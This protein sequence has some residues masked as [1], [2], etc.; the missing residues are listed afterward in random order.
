MTGI[1]RPA[2]PTKERFGPQ[3]KYEAFIS[4]KHAVSGSF[5]R[6]LELALKKY[7]RPLLKPPRQIFRDEQFLAPGI[8]LP[9]LIKNAL[10]QSRFLI[11]LV[12]KEAADSPW[13]QDELSRW[14]MQLGRTEQLIVVLTKDEIVTRKSSKKK[15]IEWSKTTALPRLLKSQLRTIPLY[16]DARTFSKEEHLDLEHP[17]FKALVNGIVARLRGIT[18]GEMSDEAVLQHRR[19]VR[20]RNITLSSLMLLILCTILALAFAVNRQ[21]LANQQREFRA[22]LQYAADI[23]NVAQIYTGD[24]QKS[25]AKEL[26][27][28]INH[29]SEESR[30]KDLRG[31]EWFLLWRLIQ[32]ELPHIGSKGNDDTRSVAFSPVS[33]NILA[34]GSFDGL[35]IYNI[36]SISQSESSLDATAHVWSIAFSPD[37][38]TLAVGGT[39]CSVTLWDI[40]KRKKTATLMEP[41]PPSNLQP[42][43]ART[44]YVWSVA[45]SPSGSTLATAHWDGVVRVWDIR[46]HRLLTKIKE[47]ERDTRAVAFSRDGKFLAAGG[48]EGTIKVYCSKD[49]SLARTLVHS[50]DAIYSLRF[51]PNRNQLASGSG[52]GTV[53]IWSY[54][55]GIGDIRRDI[56]DNKPG[57]IY[58]LAYSPDGRQL[59]TGSFS[60]ITT[61]WDFHNMKVVSKLEGHTK[62]VWSIDFAKD[63]KLLAIGNSFPRRDISLWDTSQLQHSVLEGK[64]DAAFCL[65]FS[66]DSNLLASGHSGGVVKIWDIRTS[67]MVTSF[68]LETKSS[69]HLG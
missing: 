12:S 61:I 47:E 14:C 24:L 38:S 40:T 41:C 60:G 1:H 51:A 53:V 31:I 22:Q 33:N 21:L 64:G 5:A 50:G 65:A 32:P 66:S 67:T 28:S 68:A 3:M 30:E 4:Y 62:I 54:E 34:S 42:S 29:Q 36:S 27:L 57:M 16:I 17:D 10:D 58:A 56:L 43:Q 20:T 7:A 55:A 46:S 59:A 26:L 25:T 63:G 18:P 48:D 9:G 52:D 39:D 23:S 13:V 6:Q 15:E 2:S 49:Y 11:L 37:G 45:F 8:D 19:N 44:R 35:K 69:I